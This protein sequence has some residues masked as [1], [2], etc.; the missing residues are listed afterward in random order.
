MSA[1]GSVPIG[2][3][4]LGPLQAFYIMEHACG[5]ELIRKHACAKHVHIASMCTL[6]GMGL[7]VHL[8]AKKQYL[9]ALAPCLI[10]FTSG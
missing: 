1:A 5:F 8:N 3:W 7:V 6:R 2:E 4:C 9:V 10:A